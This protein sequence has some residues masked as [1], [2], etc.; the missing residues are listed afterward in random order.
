[1]LRRTDGALVIVPEAAAAEGVL[2][3]EVDGWRLERLL[4]SAAALAL[5]HLWRGAKQLH[6][7]EGWGGG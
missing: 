4:A 3:Q 5:K 7:G 2:A 1:M 6:L